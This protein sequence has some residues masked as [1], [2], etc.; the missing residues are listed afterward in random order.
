VNHGEEEPSSARQDQADSGPSNTTEGL[1]GESQTTQDMCDECKDVPSLWHCDA[2]DWN[3]CAGC[4]DERSL[5]QRGDRGHNRLAYTIQLVSGALITFMSNFQFSKGFRNVFNPLWTAEDYQKMHDEDS[6]AAWFGV[7]KSQKE[8]FSFDILPRYAR[9]ISAYRVRHHEF[10]TCYP[11]LVSFVGPRGG[12]KSTLARILLERPWLQAGEGT[13]FSSLAGTPVVRKGNNTLPTSGDVNLYGCDDGIEGHPLFY[14]DC[15]GLDGGEVAPSGAFFQRW[16]DNSAAALSGMWK[17]FKPAR[18][19]SLNN[20][21][22]AAEPQA[23]SREVAITKLLPRLLYN[24]SDVIVFVVGSRESGGMENVLRRV[25][26]WAQISSASAVNRTSLPHLV[27][28]LNGAENFEETAWDPKEATERVFAEHKDAVMTNAGILEIKKRYEHNSVAISDLESL[29]KKSYGS[30]QFLWI[31]N[32]FNGHNH[33]RLSDQ[34]QK[35]LEITNARSRESQDLK[36]QCALLLSSQD[37]E[38]FFQHAFSHY[39]EHIDEPLNIIRELMS[40]NPMP[41]SLASKIFQFLL[42]VDAAQDEDLNDALY[43]FKT[44]AP[45]IASALA[46]DAT[47][48]YRRVPGRTS[49][50]FRGNLLPHGN[51][52]R[53]LYHNTYEFYIQKA[54]EELCEKYIPC[55]YQDRFGRTC[56]NSRLSHKNINQHQDASGSQIGDGPFDSHSNDGLKGIWDEVLEDH[57]KNADTEISRRMEAFVEKSAPEMTL[58]K[59]RVVWSVH[60]ENLTKLY[61]TLVRLDTR[62]LYRMCAWC[63]TRAPFKVTPCDHAICSACAK[64]ECS[65]RDNADYQR[66]VLLYACPLHPQE[67]PFD[68]P[69]VMQLRPHFAGVRILSLDGG[70][71]RGILEAK[72]LAA[73]EAILR[74]RGGKIQIQ[75]FFD[76]I[77]GT[78]TG[79]LLAIGQGVKNWTTEECAGHYKSLCDK[80]FTKHPFWKIFSCKY[81]EEPFE[82]ALKEVVGTGPM[83]SAQVSPAERQFLSKRGNLREKLE[84]GNEVNAHSSEISI[85]ATKDAGSRACIFANYIRDSSDKVLSCKCL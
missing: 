6:E 35:L 5:H 16:R 50:I 60:R 31:P 54:V 81:N 19:L 4:Y 55:E 12:G 80:A 36:T 58:Q 76:L 11:R 49:D 41:D 13:R 30:I 46:L 71:V 72:V 70:G 67:M 23:P 52:P 47:R 25:L 34:L 82:K 64:A 74:G 83:I 40:L 7:S 84:H 32:G 15:E 26:D 8:E 78:S 65:F 42:A 66:F 51:V 68:L 27:V 39:S 3:Y 62:R 61:S 1:G 56:V 44:A 45:V 77:A 17:F 38:L 24:F 73:I 10:M 37:Q 69:F 43:M 14:A 9:L 57:I 79:G 53:D 33:S 28:V 18:S 85:T 75:R 48:F 22:T 29:L 2:C 21:W 63:L 59:V 20:L